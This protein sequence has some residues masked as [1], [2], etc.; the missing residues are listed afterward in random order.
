M[1]LKHFKIF[2]FAHFK[3]KKAKSTMPYE[4]ERNVYSVEGKDLEP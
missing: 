1:D 4:S 3:I 2:I